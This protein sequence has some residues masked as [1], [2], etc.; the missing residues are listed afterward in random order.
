MK[1]LY[2]CIG[3]VNHHDG[4]GIARREI[5]MRLVWAS[6]A[7]EASGLMR[8]AYG[9]DLSGVTCTPA[10]GTPTQEPA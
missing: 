2:L 4:V 5:V 6:A 9:I 8:A 7:E 1:T 10:L 3:T